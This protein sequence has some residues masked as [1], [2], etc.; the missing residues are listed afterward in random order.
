ME[1]L[2]DI[3]D[4][5]TVASSTTFSYGISGLLLRFLA[6]LIITGGIIR[7]LYYPRS[8]RRDYFFSFITDFHVIN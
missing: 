5:E 7:F 6:N 2:L 3:L 1:L 8:K 4:P